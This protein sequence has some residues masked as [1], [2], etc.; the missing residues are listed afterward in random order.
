MT[1]LTNLAG[2]LTQNPVSAIVTNL[3]ELPRSSKVPANSYIYGFSV[4]FGSDLGT[5]FGVFANA[6]T[7]SNTGFNQ[8]G[9]LIPSM[10]NGTNYFVLKGVS[11]TNGLTDGLIGFF[12]GTKLDYEGAS[13]KGSAARIRFIADNNFENP[14]IRWHFFSDSTIPD[15]STVLEGSLNNYGTFCIQALT[16]TT[17]QWE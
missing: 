17:K 14:L 2:G 6:S 3:V 13:F 1:T 4:R 15:S 12:T 10:I 16:T 8:I 5:S 9:N 7:T 11:N